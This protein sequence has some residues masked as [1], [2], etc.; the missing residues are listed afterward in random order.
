V[1]AQLEIYGAVGNK[2]N[3]MRMKNAQ[4][5]I[6]VSSFAPGVYFVKIISGEKQLTKKFVKM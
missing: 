4:T 6:D 2:V 1:N 3:A 5:S